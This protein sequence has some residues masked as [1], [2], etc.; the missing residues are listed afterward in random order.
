MADYL[1]RMSSDN[2]LTITTGSNAEL[3]LLATISAIFGGT[4]IPVLLSHELQEATNNDAEL[5]A[6][7]QRM[8]DGW[9]PKSAVA[10]ELRP[11]FDVRDIQSCSDDGLLMKDSMVVMPRSLRRCALELAHEGHPGIVKMKQWCCSTIWWPRINTDV[12]RC[13]QQYVHLW[14]VNASKA[15]T[16]AI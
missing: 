3:N 12:E 1:S 10:A 7:L 6:V 11:Y 15:G 13:V 14:Q 16:T 8:T 2:V 5:Q 4:D 9:E